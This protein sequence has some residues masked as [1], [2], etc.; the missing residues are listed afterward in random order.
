MSGSGGGLLS[1]VLSSALGGGS[2]SGQSSSTQPYIMSG[3]SYQAATDAA[4][5]QVNAAQIA[6]KVATENTNTAIQALMGE[7]ATGLTYANPTIN[8]GNQAA[9]QMNYMMGLPAVSPG[10]APTAPTAP[11]LADAAK[12][13]SQAQL[14]QAAQGY[15]SGSVVPNAAGQNFTFGLYTGPGAYNNIPQLYKDS[16]ANGTAG[17][18][19][20]GTGKYTNLGGYDTGLS[21]EP[22]GAGVIDQANAVLANPTIS[23]A[24]KNDLAQQYLDQTL[25]PKYDQQKQVYDQQNNQW[26]QQNNLY[27]TYTQK[28]VAT[29]NDVGAI[30]NNI[31]GFQYAQQQ[32]LSQIQNAASASGMLNS[33]NLLR[34]L[35]Q[36]GQQLSQTYYQNYMG[37]L[38]N[39]ANMGQ[40]ATSQAISGANQTGAQTSNAYQNLG[41][42]QANAALAAGQATASSYLTPVYNQNVSM[43]PYSTSSSSSGGSGILGGLLGGFGL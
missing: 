25:T 43:T 20:L 19:L 40:N 17:G 39:L 28:G 8:T 3:P 35:D 32:G 23:A 42:T 6:A 10:P 33:G 29:G 36:F 4:Q 16:Q 26:N 5:A 14:L 7:Y 24:L 38:G 41:S 15:I 13:I 37:N 27:N 1:G 22:G 30:I 18:S 11:T 9:A 34:G 21:M 12:N 31:P 2:Q